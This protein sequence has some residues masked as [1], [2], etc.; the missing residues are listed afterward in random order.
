MTESTFSGAFSGAGALAERARQALG[1][2]G[3]QSTAEPGAAAGAGSEQAA[4]VARDNQVNYLPGEHKFEI[5][6][7][8]KLTTISPMEAVM[9]VLQN[10]YRALA[11]TT[12]RQTA[13]MQDQVNQIN[14]ANSWLT[15]LQESEDGSF[16]APPGERSEALKKW[17]RDNDIDPDDL[18]DLSPKE[19][20]EMAT[21]FS[22]YVDQLS[23]TND[24]KMLSLKT[25]VN[26]SQEAL[27]AADGV[28]QELKQL[29]QTINNNIGR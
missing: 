10:R 16:H 5:M 12:A 22:N 20:D 19:R 21:K 9:V 28:L 27:T 14:E 23:S 17:M 25:A 7:D 3:T 24:L 6:V 2:D 29:M 1:F 26:K 8:G 13:E 15:A 18:K 11:D 4:E